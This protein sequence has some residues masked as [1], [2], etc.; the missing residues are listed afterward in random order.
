MA[1]WP[2][3]YPKNCP[4]PKSIDANGIVFRLVKNDPPTRSDFIPTSKID[5]EE[6][7]DKKC[8]ACGISVCTHVDD[9]TKL[10]S[11]YKHFRDRKIASGE[12]NPLLGKMLHTPFNEKSHHT[13][14]I[15]EDEDPSALFSVI[16]EE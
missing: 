13:W 14:W 11:R 15:P 16:M 4:N 3:F 6:S 10:R 8:T 9:I 12:L 2:D 7:D 5:P 1:K